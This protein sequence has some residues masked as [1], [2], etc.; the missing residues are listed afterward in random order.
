LEGTGP[1]EG[2]SLEILAASKENYTTWRKNVINCYQKIGSITG[3]TRLGSPNYW[4]SGVSPA[5]KRSCIDLDL[6]E[7]SHFRDNAISFDCHV[8]VFIGIP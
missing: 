3:R 8:Q 2:S 1:I 6:T 7:I 5:V 4:A